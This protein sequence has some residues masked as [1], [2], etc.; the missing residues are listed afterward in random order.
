MQTLD[1]VQDREE[2]VEEAEHTEVHPL[3]YANVC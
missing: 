1:D 3:A 2:E